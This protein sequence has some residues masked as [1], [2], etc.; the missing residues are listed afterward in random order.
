MLFTLHFITSSAI[1]IL[2]N[3]KSTPSQPQKDDK[4]SLKFL[5]KNDATPAKARKLSMPLHLQKEL[6]QK[7]EKLIEYISVHNTDVKV[8][9]SI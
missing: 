5:P 1:S 8:I 2:V 4:M 6:E 7:R 9:S 3:P